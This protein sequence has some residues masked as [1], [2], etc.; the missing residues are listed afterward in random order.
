MLT[1]YRISMHYFQILLRLFQNPSVAIEEAED[2]ETF[3]AALAGQSPR[4]II[5]HAQASLETLL[6]AYYLRH[7][8]EWLDTYLVALLAEVCYTTI[9][10]MT[11]RRS[12][13]DMTSLQSSII[14]L[15]K[16]IY[17]Q[18][19]SFFLG[20]IIFRFVTEKMRP[21]DLKV[22][23]QLVKIEPA[24]DAQILGLQQIQME[25]P[26]EI[27]SM[28]DDPDSKRLGDL[29]KKSEDGNGT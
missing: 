10:A 24:N 29:L 21:E 8:F 3:A 11:P 26:V 16:G 27:I 15:A 5:S 20:Q 19:Q 7:S 12:H 22:L 2:R 1:N 9:G 13:Q 28:A 17:E 18:G 4:Q 14:L 23:K 6:R 25:W